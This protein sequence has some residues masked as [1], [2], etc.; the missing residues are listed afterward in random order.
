MPSIPGDKSRYTQSLPLMPA[1]AA[2]DP[3]HR[4]PAASSQASQCPP[5]ARFIEYNS[6]LSP[7]RLSRLVTSAAIPIHR[8]NAQPTRQSRSGISHA[9]SATAFHFAD[10]VVW[11]VRVE[12]QKLTRRAASEL[13]GGDHSA[14]F[15]R[16]AS[17]RRSRSATPWERPRFTWEAI[18]CRS[19]KRQGRAPCGCRKLHGPRASTLTL[20]CPPKP[21]H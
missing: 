7:E 1:P 17:Q 18:I 3:R 2:Q 4:V 19:R 14:H 9:M 20:S 11:R 21:L 13:P 16:R 12:S 6:V 5:A 8:D 10:E 15:V